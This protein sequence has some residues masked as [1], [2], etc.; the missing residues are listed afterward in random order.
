MSNRI[1]QLEDAVSQFH[2]Q[3]HALT[4]N[5]ITSTPSVHPLLTEELLRVKTLKEML[6][7]PDIV[8][9]QALSSGRLRSE[10]SGSGTS[11][12]GAT[13]RDPKAAAGTSDYV[14]AFGT[15]AIGDDG[16]ARFYGRSGGQEVSPFA[17][18]KETCSRSEAVFDPN[19]FQ[20]AARVYCL[21]VPL[22]SGWL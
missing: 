6:D 22:P 17:R 16:A 9:E 1:R 18:K 10:P 8:A 19:L 7:N 12:S 14:E 3:V 13:D 4:T 5:E 11:A 2:R 21:Y 15:L 20:I